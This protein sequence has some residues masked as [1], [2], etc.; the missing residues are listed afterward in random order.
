MKA[1]WT[2]PISS[3]ATAIASSI[4]NLLIKLSSELVE[5]YYISIF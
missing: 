1:V 4:G 2:P 5:H 3:A